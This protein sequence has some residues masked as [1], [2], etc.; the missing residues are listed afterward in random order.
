MTFE[1]G[2]LTGVAAANAAAETRMA[3]MNFM[4]TDS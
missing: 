3:E 2:R 1:A 4:L